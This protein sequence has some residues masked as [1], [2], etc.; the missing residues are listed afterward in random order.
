MDGIRELIGTNIRFL[1]KERGLSQAELGF[2]INSDAPLI[3][4]YERGFLTPSVETIFQLCA[5]LQ[6]PLQAILPM[7][8]DPAHAKLER[9]KRRIV[10]QICEVN[11]LDTI[12]DISYFIEQKL[13]ADVIERTNHES[14]DI[15]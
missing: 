6:V 2:M 10:E 14:M 15:D 9:I 12:L 11:E 7:L 1:R 5:A 13:E 4:R 8:Y 3:S